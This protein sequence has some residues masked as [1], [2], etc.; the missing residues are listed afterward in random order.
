M[1]NIKRRNAK[2]IGQT[3][4]GYSKIMTVD[5]KDEELGAVDKDVQNTIKDIFN[6]M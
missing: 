5:E 1:E 3:C 6:K 4:S 2:G